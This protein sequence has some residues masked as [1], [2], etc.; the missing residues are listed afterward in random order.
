MLSNKITGVVVNYD[1]PVLLRNAIDSIRK[2]YDFEIIVIDNSLEPVE[3]PD[4]RLIKT[5]SNIGHGPGMDM[6]IKLARTPF[7]LLFDSDILLIEPCIDMMFEKINDNVYAVG[8]LYVRNNKYFYEKHRDLFVGDFAYI[9][10]PAFHL[11]NRDQYYNFAPY[12]SDGSPTVLSYLDIARQ[13][14]QHMLV[15]FPV[16]NYV[17]HLKAGTRNMLENTG[18]FPEYFTTNP[19]KGYIEKWKEYLNGDGFGKRNNN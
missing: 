16:F 15:D 17:N 19:S 1:T 10:D 4:T 14:K 2:Y 13:N 12:I 11:L 6:G 8:K 9:I 7:V 3:I 18:R 5:G